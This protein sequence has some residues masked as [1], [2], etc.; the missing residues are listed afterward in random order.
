MTQ[1]YIATFYSHFGA[2]R[3]KKECDKYGWT[4]QMMPVPR[5]LSS[6]CGTCVRFTMENA[7]GAKDNVETFVPTALISDELEQIVRVEAPGK[8]TEVYRA[9]GA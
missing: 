7:E 5:D 1:T 9:E 8:Y 3:A 6:S 4:A 2:M